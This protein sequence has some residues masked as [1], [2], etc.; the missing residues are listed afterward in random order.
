MSRARRHGP[1][2]SNTANRM[3]SSRYDTP[4][5]AAAAATE[6]AVTDGWTFW[7]A[8]TEY[9]TGTLAELA[10]LESAPT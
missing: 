5:A 4:D 9:G 1:D 3:R 7:A 10:E 6:G 8:E 2:R